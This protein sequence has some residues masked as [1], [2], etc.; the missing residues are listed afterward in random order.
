MGRV[1]SYPNMLLN[2][3]QNA[4]VCLFEK[5]RP[6]QNGNRSLFFVAQPLTFI[7]RPDR[8]L[9]KSTRASPKYEPVVQ[10]EQ[11]TS[12]VLNLFPK[13]SIFGWDQSCCDLWS[14]HVDF[15]KAADCP[16]PDPQTWPRPC[17]KHAAILVKSDTPTPPIHPSTLNSEKKSKRSIVV[18]RPRGEHWKNIIWD[19]GRTSWGGLTKGM[20]F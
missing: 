9:D 19:A 8:W 1:F 17:W 3:G 16:W 11:E 18:K 13:K 2:K 5:I 15:T 7:W 10:S 6:L 4:F 20:L 14:G 12:K